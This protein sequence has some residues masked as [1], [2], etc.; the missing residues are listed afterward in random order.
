VPPRRIKPAV[1]AA[2]EAVCL[3]ALARRPA[4]RYPSAQGL[5]AD[6]ARWLADE[7][8][9][10]WPEPWRVQARRWGR[11]HRAL[12]TAA[13]AAG[14]VTLVGLV[15]GLVLVGAAAE[16]QAMARKVAEDKGEETRRV[17][18]GAQMNLVQRDYE[19]GNLAHTREL[20]QGQA[21]WPAGK[22]NLRGFEWY[23]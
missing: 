2:L 16:E 18:Y 21:S 11:R 17:L 1:P 8:L 19:A 4:D 10:A 13:L 5:A 20:L 23:Y 6:V 15:V 7:P 12:V 14:A 9:S 3:K 22:E